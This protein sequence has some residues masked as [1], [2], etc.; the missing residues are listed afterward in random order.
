M[1]RTMTKTKTWARVLGCFVLCGCGATS[2][3]LRDATTVSQ[4][5]YRQDVAAVRYVRSA[6]GSATI[7][8]VF[9]AIPVS[10]GEAPYKDAMVAL[11]KD[12]ALKPNEVL[13][14]IRED[15]TITAYLVFYCTITLTISGDVIEL[16]PL[17][18]ATPAASPS[19]TKPTTDARTDAP[20][21]ADASSAA[22]S[23]D[24]DRAYDD[25]A[26]LIKPFRWLY[27]NAAFLVPPPPRARFVMACADQPEDVQR[28]L[29]GPY[30]KAHA[31]ECKGTFA[32]L[33]SKARQR[34]FAVFLSDYE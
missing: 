10:G 19:S 20:T 14:N 29:Q 30:L 15:H 25:L 18:T 28:C 22:A 12:A 23:P 21:E 2:G 24:C 17:A 6:A 7:G 34:L 9:C 32:Q 16:I 4:H 5:Q 1:M 31:D 13:E 11:H 3:F 33:A 26:Q 27:P 8:S